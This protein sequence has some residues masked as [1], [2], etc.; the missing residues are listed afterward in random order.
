MKSPLS[1]SSKLFLIRATTLKEFP[2][3]MRIPYLL[4]MGCLIQRWTHLS[5]FLFGSIVLL[6][7]PRLDSLVLGLFSISHNLSS[8]R[9]STK[10]SS[11]DPRFFFNKFLHDNASFLGEAFQKHIITAIHGFVGIISAGTSTTIAL[12]SRRNVKRYGFHVCA[13]VNLVGLRLHRRGI[14]REGAVANFV[15]TEQRVV[16]GGHEFSFVQSRGS[17]PAFWTQIPT[18]TIKPKIDPQPH[19]RHE[20]IAASRRH[21]KDQ[22]AQY[23]KQASDVSLRR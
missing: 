15:E 19:R 18:L 9:L 11:S 22:V 2:T 1:T 21:F 23:G 12:I 13:N 17:I 4:E 14:D 3:N 5:I 7:K 16:S 10:P 20:T 8:Q 6:Y